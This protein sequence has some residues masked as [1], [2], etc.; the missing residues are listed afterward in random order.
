MKATG[1]V[2]LYDRFIGLRFEPDAA[3]MHRSMQNVQTSDNM[4]I[5]ENRQTFRRGI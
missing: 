2:D 5:V 4:E 1:Y 3:V